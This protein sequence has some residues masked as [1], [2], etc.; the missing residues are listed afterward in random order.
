MIRG[1]VIYTVV[2][3]LLLVYA[4]AYGWRLID[5]FTSGKWGP[6]MQAHYHK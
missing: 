3:G 2:L 5:A 6:H 1:Y 4:N